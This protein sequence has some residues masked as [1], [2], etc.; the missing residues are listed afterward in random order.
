MQ[1]I[2]STYLHPVLSIE[3]RKSIINFVIDS[4]NNIKNYDVIL[5]S[6]ASGLL[7]GPIVSHLLEKPIGIIRKTQD[8]EP[9]HSW[10]VY[11]GIEYYGKYVI[12]DDLVD[13][14]ET[15]KRIVDVSESR[16]PSAKCAGLIMYNQSNCYN[17]KIDNEIINRIFPGQFIP[18]YLK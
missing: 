6:G 2:Y 9:R 16:N 7:V 8:G 12:V 1:E 13:S 17:D 18:V 3:A 14:G 11:E 5:V 10:R 15:L 4:L